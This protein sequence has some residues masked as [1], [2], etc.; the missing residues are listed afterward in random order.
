LNELT[1]IHRL[2]LTE[3][4]RRAYKY[5]RVKNSGQMTDKPALKIPHLLM[6]DPDWR[7][8]KLECPQYGKYV[9]TWPKERTNPPDIE[10]LY[11]NFEPK[12]ALEEVV[13]NDDNGYEGEMEDA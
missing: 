6:I 5:K 8:G 1:R 3:A 12:D 9:I 7:Q 10:Q 13:D 11:Q 4:E 2:G